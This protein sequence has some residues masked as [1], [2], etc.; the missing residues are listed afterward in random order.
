MIKFHLYGFQPGEKL[1]AILSTQFAFQRLFLNQ[2]F[3]QRTLCLIFSLRLLYNFVQPI[4]RFHG[5]KLHSFKAAFAGLL[6]MPTA[7]ECPLDPRNEARFIRF[8]INSLECRVG[9]CDRSC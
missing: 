3:F 4:R 8:V 7:R 6:L 1:S 5:R 2:F 9:R